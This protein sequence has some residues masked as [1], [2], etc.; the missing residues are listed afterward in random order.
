M[1]AARFLAAMAHGAASRPASKSEA[2]GP[3][4][5]RRTEG[6]RAAAGWG[7]GC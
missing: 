1:Y 4:G 3:E 5:L 7:A 6:G 2:G